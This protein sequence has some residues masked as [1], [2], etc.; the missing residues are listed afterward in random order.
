MKDKLQKFLFED[1]A[2][3]GEL[4][5]ISLAWKQVQERHDYP[6][7]VSNLLGEMMSAAALLSA[8][9]K[10]DGSMIMQIHGDGPLQLLVVECDSDLRMRATAKIAAGATIADNATL[11]DLVHTH[12]KG[13]FVITLDPQNKQPGQQ[14]YQ[15]IV[16]L[17]GDTIAE[18]IENYMQQSEQLDT[19]IWLAANSEVTRGLLLQRLP[20]PN[21]DADD[22]AKK[23]QE[24]ETW[25][26]VSMLG[27]T[28]RRDEMLESDSD[29]L[30]HR[31]F[32]E[33]TLR[34]FDPQEPV[35]HCTCSRRKVGDMLK[36]LGREEIEDAL[37]E[38]G[39]LSI[40]CDFCGQSYDFDPVDCAQLFVTEI[41]E[42]LAPPPGDSIH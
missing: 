16:P 5:E 30:M 9:L 29:T 20:Q 26:R 15:G 32:W 21:S 40:R 42:D 4:V 10:F 14:P 6:P 28:L 11:L 3:R 1:A 18:V 38:Q 24:L 25:R 31:L 7:L 2:I 13:R 39:K 35:F 33:E 23:E 12:G 34:I 19:R 37:Q 17:E 22:P 36:M 41:P 8:N 27:A